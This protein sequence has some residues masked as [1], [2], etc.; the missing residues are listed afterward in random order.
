[1][2]LQSIASS[3]K[4]NYKTVLKWKQ[5][6]VWDE[7]RLEY[8]SG[9]KAF[10]ERLYNFSQTIMD[11]IEADIK[12]GQGANPGR[13]YTFTKLLPLI[14]KIKQY[15]DLVIKSRPVEKNNVLSEQDVREIEELLGLRKYTKAEV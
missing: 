14:M 12:N 9:K 6:G 7:M 10:H 13:L 8:L 5:E 1:M 11:S 15:E 3:L 4:L 2:S